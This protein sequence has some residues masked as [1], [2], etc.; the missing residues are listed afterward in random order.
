[1]RPRAEA[2]SREEKLNPIGVRGG[3]PEPG[4]LRGGVDVLESQ[5]ETLKAPCGILSLQIPEKYLHL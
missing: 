1:M 3:Q 5:V 4:R 2:L